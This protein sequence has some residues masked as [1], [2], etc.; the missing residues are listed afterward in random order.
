MCRNEK[1]CRTRSRGA[2]EK[3]S[4][5]VKLTSFVVFLSSVLLRV[6]NQIITDMQININNRVTCFDY[7]EADVLMSANNLDDA[8]DV[9][10]AADDYL[11]PCEPCSY[12]E[13]LITPF[14]TDERQCE[15]V[16]LMA[17]GLAWN[18][19]PLPF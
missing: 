9:A 13:Q 5:P 14:G 4:T 15:H 16:V 19:E 2:T 11:G 3:E 10:L 6:I 7:G 17:K 1:L 8:L 18:H 12:Y